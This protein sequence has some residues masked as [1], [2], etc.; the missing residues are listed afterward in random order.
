M[1]KAVPIFTINSRFEDIFDN[2]VV[3]E[4][5]FYNRLLE[6]IET[7]L[8]SNY[9]TTVLCYL[10]DEEGN[11]SEATLEEEGYYKSLQKCINYYTEE[12]R[13]EVCSRIIKL[14]EKNEL[15]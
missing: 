6:F 13:Y 3:E 8:S 2:P 14:I 1:D 4:K 12:E 9:K 11:L 10:E 5:E 15:R 7:N